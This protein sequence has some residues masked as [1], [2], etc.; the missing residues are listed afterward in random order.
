MASHPTGE[1]DV[2]AGSF[3]LRLVD[4][5]GG[6]VRKA[7]RADGFDR[8]GTSLGRGICCLVTPQEVSKQVF[9]KKHSSVSLTLLF[10]RHGGRHVKN[11]GAH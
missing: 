5:D 3:S 4:S 8:D 2:A 1:A 6:G 7:D 11:N 9:D 10:S